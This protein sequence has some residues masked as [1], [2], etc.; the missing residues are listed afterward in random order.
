MPGRRS[1]AASVAALRLPSLLAAMAV[2]ATTAVVGRRLVGRRAALVAALVLGASPGLVRYGQEARSYALV[3]LLA[4]LLW[5]AALRGV[6][7]RRADQAG[8]AGRWWAVVALV[9]V[10]GVLAHGMFA[11]QV[12]ALA[13][14]L[15]VLPE[16]SRL[17]RDVAP[18]VV[19]TVAVVLGLSALGADAIA[20]WVEPLSVAQLGDVARELLAPLP[21]RP[22]P[23]ARRPPPV[24]WCSSVVD[25]RI[26]STAGVP[27][28]RSR[29]RWCPS[30]CS[31]RCRRSAPT[32]CP[33]TCWARCP[34]WPCWWA[35]PSTPP[36]PGPGHRPRRAEAAGSPRSPS[37][38]SWC[39][40]LVAGQLALHRRTGD[41]WA[42]AARTVA[43]EARPGDAVVF[44]SAPV[45]IP[46]EAAWQDTDPASVPTAVWA[47]RPLGEVRRFDEQTTPEEL[48]EDLAD[49]D[50][51]W[52]VHQ[53][54]ESTGD[55]GRDEMLR[56]PPVR[57]GFRVEARHRLDGDVQ[58]LLLVRR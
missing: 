56:F 31:W 11:L 14:S 24:P 3:A 2:V 1:R 44:S 23:S 52:L 17:L 6:E 54:M 5:A 34:R 37:P 13:G 19:A 25:R 55:E 32:S 58:V 39:S 57:D 29:G 47:D 18:A 50:R 4:T 43:A 10:L 49:V 20:D 53:T 38:R 16:R 27:L 41:D 40:P 26:R 21:W 9:A 35:S 22:P 51:L 30:C 8:A 33:A 36:G 12:V 15:L 28:R 45:R 42:G 48:E 46:F 7:A